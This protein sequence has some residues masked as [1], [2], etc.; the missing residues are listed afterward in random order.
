V[1]EPFELGDEPSGLAFGVAASEVLAAEVVVELARAQHVPDRAE[2][3]VFDGAERTAVTELGFLATVERLEVAV[4]GPQRGHR[5]VGK[6]RVEVLA[7]L[8][9][10]MSR[11]IRNLR[12][13]DRWVEAVGQRLER[14]DRRVSQR[15]IARGRLAEGPQKGWEHVVGVD[16][17]VVEP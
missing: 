2:H 10:P 16:E 5:S 17:V 3:R 14:G 13:F 9:T 12:V 4:V 6:R 11:E 7:A 1:S 8:V 15:W